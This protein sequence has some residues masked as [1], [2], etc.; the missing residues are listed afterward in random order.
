MPW[1]QSPGHV[2]KEQPLDRVAVTGEHLGDV[3]DVVEA[4][5][6]VGHDEAALRDVGACRRQRDGR[7]QARDVVVAE[8]ADDG[9]SLRHRRLSLRE[10]EEARARAHEAVPPEPALLH[11]LEQERP[12]AALPAHAEVGP[13]WSEEVGVDVCRDRHGKQ[14][15]PSGGRSSSGTGFGP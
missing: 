6:P 3:R 5:E 7:L 14:K 8:V 2:C 12:G 1:A 15:R 13:E 10:R 9:S 11:R 4:D